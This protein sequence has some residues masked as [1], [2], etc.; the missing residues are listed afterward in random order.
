LAYHTDTIAARTLEVQYDARCPG[1]SLRDRQIFG[2]TGSGASLGR[3]HHRNRVV[4]R[5]F[6]ALLEDEDLRQR[7]AETR[8]PQ[9]IE[10]SCET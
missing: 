10:K 2:V 8:A 5:L 4:A 1:T 3:A 7:I 6:L 9:L